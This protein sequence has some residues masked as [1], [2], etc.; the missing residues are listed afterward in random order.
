MKIRFFALFLISFVAVKNYAQ[1]SLNGVYINAFLVDPTLNSG[2]SFDTD[3]DGTAAAQDE[4][5]QICNGST[6]SVSISGWTISEGG[7][8][9]FEFNGTNGP[10][11]N[12]IS[13]SV[14]SIAAG[15]CYTVLRGLNG[16]SLKTNMLDWGYSGGAL[17]N[18]SD[19]IILSNG[20]SSCTISYTTSNWT[21]GC[22]SV[23]GTGTGNGAA[24]CSLT[25]ASLGSSPLPVELLQFNANKSDEAIVLN[26]ATASELN[27]NY[28]DIEKSLNGIDFYTIG[29]VGGAGTSTEIKTYSYTNR[30]I[31][32]INYYRLKQV[33]FDGEFEYSK[34]VK[35]ADRPTVVSFNEEQNYLSINSISEMDARILVMTSNGILL[36]DETFGNETKIDHQHYSSGTY[37]ITVFAEGRAHNYRLIK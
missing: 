20:S 22:A 15:E 18:N 3:G 16:G 17:N 6:S 4:F 21:S 2:N 35:V 9:A 28:F 19:D 32:P 12:R 11:T 24:D 26:W 7:G 5:I 36:K 1:C 34:T 30:N 10:A 8:Q 37:F 25:P 27:N 33:D 13:N 31:A 29:R 14:T 23:V